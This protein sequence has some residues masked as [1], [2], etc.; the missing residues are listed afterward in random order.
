MSE[1]KDPRERRAAEISKRFFSLVLCSSY[2]SLTL[3]RKEKM[4]K[5]NDYLKL[6]LIDFCVLWKQYLNCGIL[7]ITSLLF[8]F[9]FF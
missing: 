2:F 4:T 1:I 5:C 6:K 3:F 9:L 7:I 8:I